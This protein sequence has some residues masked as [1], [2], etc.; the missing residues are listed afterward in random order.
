MFLHLVLTRPRSWTQPLCNGRLGAFGAHPGKEPRA[1]GTPVAVTW[2]RLRIHSCSAYLVDWFLA[3]P[4]AGPSHGGVKPK[5][6]LSWAGVGEGLVTHGMGKPSSQRLRGMFSGNG[7][8][9]EDY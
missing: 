1:S 5:V 3:T 8:P 9:R 7:N 4:K 2:P 6:A